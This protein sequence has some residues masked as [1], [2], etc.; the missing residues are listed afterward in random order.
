MLDL[1]IG[2]GRG[3][4]GFFGSFSLLNLAGEMHHPGFDANLWWI[5]LR[6]L[7]DLPA[8]VLLALTG[9]LLLAYAIQ[10]A[11]RRWRCRATVATAATL[12]VFAMA[13]AIGFHVLVARGAIGAECPVA[14][15]WLVAAGL[16]LV[17]AGL[18]VRSRQAPERAK[19]TERSAIVLTVAT[20]LVGFPLAQMCCFGLTDYRRPADVAV[21][22]GARVYANGQPSLALADR[23]R[24]GCA[25]YRSGF[26]DK[27]IFSG[28][29]GDGAIHETVAMRRLA[30]QLGLPA[31]DI[32]I[33][34]QGVNTEATARHTSAMFASL[35]IRRV[36]AVS[37]FYHL[38]R[39]K[40]TYQRYGWSVNTVPARQSRWLVRLPW[41]MAREIAA[42][43]LYYLR[44]LAPSAAGRLGDQNASSSLKRMCCRASRMSEGVAV[45]S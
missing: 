3:T 43:W 18:W 37:H 23:V 21:V 25:L 41:Y 12:L 15:S 35:G 8:R 24:T 16:A 33:D 30:L 39:V 20:C 10:P 9:T 2:V 36:L 17:S 42:L 28:G 34:E 4:A 22:L 31:D 26:V 6:P 45:G 40:L 7:P 11:C 29:P 32:L 14:F 19:S 27:V 1:W 44:P 5:D 38:P 13:N